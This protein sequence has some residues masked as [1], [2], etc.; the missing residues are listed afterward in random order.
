[1]NLIFLHNAT[2]VVNGSF[3][4]LLDSCV[5]VCMYS[6]KYIGKTSQHDANTAK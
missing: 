4:D 6:E 2:D 3:E 1:M 5:F